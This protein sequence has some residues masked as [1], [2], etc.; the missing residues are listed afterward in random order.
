MAAS[1]WVLQCLFWGDARLL[2]SQSHQGPVPNARGLGEQSSVR[3]SKDGMH[4]YLCKGVLFP[5]NSV[6]LQPPGSILYPSFLWQKAVCTSWFRGV[7]LSLVVDGWF[8]RVL[9][10]L[11]L[12]RCHFSYSHSPHTHTFLWG[13][14]Y[15]QSSAL[16]APQMKCEF[17]GRPAEITSMHL[18]RCQSFCENSYTMKKK[19]NFQN[20]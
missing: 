18:P 17:P 15:K 8:L 3:N 9:P 14:L 10:D 16:N 11:I 2:P 7:G 13:M 6:L 12:L 1:L 5:F 19:L 20:F 4:A